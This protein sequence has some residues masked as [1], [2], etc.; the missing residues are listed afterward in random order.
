MVVIDSSAIVAM[1]FKEPESA[2]CATA[3][4]AASRRLI[5]AVSYVETGT[6]LAGRTSKADRDKA[7]VDLDAFISTFG[8]EVAPLTE[9][10]A[11]EALKARI[12]YGK[13]FGSKKSLN[14]SD[15]FAYAL[16][17]A[18]SAPL[19]YVGDDFARTDVERALA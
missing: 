14:F 6:V 19:L 12:R 8:I 11:R 1:M 3:M 15:C 2:A 10:L 4:G 5:S 7:L 13:G 16:A 9:D 18:H 17:K